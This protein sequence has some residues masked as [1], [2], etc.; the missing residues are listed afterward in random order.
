MMNFDLCLQAK[1]I[2]AFSRVRL[3]TNIQ[4][5]LSYT[6]HERCVRCVG[7]VDGSETDQ[8]REHNVQYTSSLVG[9]GWGTSDAEKEALTELHTK[10]V[11]PLFWDST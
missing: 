2:D 6:R 5:V 9:G 11:F 3:S 7:L 4:F 1:Q 10:T 8:P